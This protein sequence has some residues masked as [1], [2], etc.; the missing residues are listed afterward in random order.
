M[1]YLSKAD[2]LA[3]ITAEPEDLAVPGVGTVRV[4]GL[5]TYEANSLY[6]RYEKDNA[7]L[8]VRALLAGLVEP[9]FTE[10]DL[11]ALRNA[12]AGKLAP[13]AQRIM[14]LSAMSKS[15]DALGEAGGGSSD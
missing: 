10:D 11:P 15:E 8:L 14:D 2:F 7:E 6:A 5:T 12:A 9:A 1:A 4:R 3:A 13:V